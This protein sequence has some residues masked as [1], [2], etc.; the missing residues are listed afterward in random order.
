MSETI[1]RPPT[2]REVYERIQDRIKECEEREKLTA[3]KTSD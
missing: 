3:R 1:V 2:N